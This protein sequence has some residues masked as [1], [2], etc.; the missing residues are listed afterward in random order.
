MVPNTIAYSKNS[1]ALFGV[2]NAGRQDGF[3]LLNAPC[4]NVSPLHVSR[5]AELTLL[6]IATAKLIQKAWIRSNGA[7]KCLKRWP[8]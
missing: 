5:A 2:Y 3:E 8:I 1:D 4:V 7:L 6:E